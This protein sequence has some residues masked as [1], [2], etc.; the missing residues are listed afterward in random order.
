MQRLGSQERENSAKRM[1]CLP[2][3]NYTREETQMQLSK[4]STNYLRK[5][6][7]PESK[8]KHQATIHHHKLHALNFCLK[9]KEN[10]LPFSA[11]LQLESSD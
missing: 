8:C 3:I 2:H 7:V 11:N 10:V 1:S 5:W 4:P 6:S 9:V